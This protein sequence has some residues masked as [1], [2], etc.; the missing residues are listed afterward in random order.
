MLC[1]VATNYWQLL[2]ARIGVGIGEAGGTPAASSIISDYFPA[3]RRPM[4]LTVFSLGAPLG[5][6]VGYSLAGRI[7][8]VWGWRSVFLALGVPGWCSAAWSISR[9][10]SPG[11]DST[12]P[13]WAPIS[14]R[15]SR[16]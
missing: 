14:H 8:D 2:F 11:A 7:A 6:Y 9:C 16:R 4:A 15:S 10:A 12:M 13:P 5:A 1:G 3:G